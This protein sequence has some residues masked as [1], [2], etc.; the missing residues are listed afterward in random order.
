MPSIE[1]ARASASA[2]VASAPTPFSTQRG[3]RP[4]PKPSHLAT[5]KS[6]RGRSPTPSEAAASDFGAEFSSDDEDASDDDD[7]DGGATLARRSVRIDDTLRGAQVDTIQEA[8]AKGKKSAPHSSAQTTGRTP[9]KNIWATEKATYSASSS[10]PSLRPHADS[11]EEAESLSSSP[12]ASR[13]SRY[14]S[15]LS[16]LRGRPNGQQ[17]AEEAR[18]TEGLGVDVA[19]WLRGAGAERH[20][21]RP[22]SLVGTIRDQ[23]W[24]RRDVSEASAASTTPVATLKARDVTGV[25]SGDVA[26]TN[27]QV[28]EMAGISAGE[29]ALTKTDA[30][31]ATVEAVRA[32]S[33]ATGIERGARDEAQVSTSKGSEQGSAIALADEPS[34]N[35]AQPFR[36]ESIAMESDE[37][38][39][40]LPQGPR[41][42]G[43]GG[44]SQEVVESVPKLVTSLHPGTGHALSAPS[45][46]LSAP[47]AAAAVSDVEQPNIL[48]RPPPTQPKFSG[49]PAR[50]LFE[51]AGEA[52]FNELTL[53][54]GQTFEVLVPELR[55]GWSLA[56]LRD[57]ATGAE[58]R[59]LV[60]VGWYCYIQEF[61][62][63][64]HSGP[65]AA[66]GMGSPPKALALDT[67]PE[68]ISECE[69]IDEAPSSGFT[70]LPGSTLG[71]TSSLMTRSNS[72]ASTSSAS[73]RLA[74]ARA[75]AARTGSV[76]VQSPIDEDELRRPAS[77]VGVFSS[78]SLGTSPALKALEALHAANSESSASHTQIEK[79]TTTIK[80]RPQTNG[81]P[82]APVDVP[83]SDLESPPVNL[84]THDQLLSSHDDGVSTSAV[85]Q[86]DATQTSSTFTWKGPGGLLGGR[87][88][89]RFSPFVTSGVEAFLLSRKPQDVASH[90]PSSS[91]DDGA[92]DFEED[93]T[94]LEGLAPR[95]QDVQH[96]TSGAHGPVWKSRAKAFHVVVHSPEARW[97]S[98]GAAYTAYAVTSLF[99]DADAAQ[100]AQHTDAEGKSIWSPYDPALP[101]ETPLESLSVWR[102][103]SQFHWLA[104][105]ISRRAPLLAQSLPPVP[106][107]MRA[108]KSRLEAAFVEDR[109]RALGNW[110]GRLIR[111]PVARTDPGVLFF[112]GCADE[113]EWNARAPRLLREA[114]V[115]IE[116]TTSSSGP[117]AN[118]FARTT[119][120]PWGFDVGEAEEAGE[121]LQAFNAAYER[122]MG[123]ASGPFGMGIMGAFNQMRET[124]R[125]EGES[126]RHTSRAL[127]RLTTGAG[128]GPKGHAAHSESNESESAYGPAMGRLGTRGESGATNEDGAWC[129]RPDCKD[130]IAATR[131]TQSLALA[132]EDVGDLHDYHAR[133]ALLLQH[134][135]L[136][137][138]SRPAAQHAAILEVHRQTLALYR[139][140]VGDDGDEES[141]VR[142]AE[143]DAMAARCETVLNITMSEMD[144]I[145]GERVEDWIS[146]GR[147]LLDDQIALH[148][149]VLQRLQQA[150]AD[151]QNASLT[152]LQSSGPILHSSQAL[153]ELV[154]P[155]SNNGATEPLAQPTAPVLHPGV[156]ST[157]FRPV[158]LAG[159]MIGNL[160]GSSQGPTEEEMDRSTLATGGNGYAQ[161]V[162]TVRSVSN[163]AQQK[164]LG[165]GTLGSKKNTPQ[166]KGW[167]FW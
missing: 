159:E 14:A 137:A 92:F 6:R 144:R 166:S 2:L 15:A 158:T 66:Q 129:W 64:P 7:T 69:G 96:V 71:A 42:G 142:G 100:Y 126:F 29:E 49:R 133:E 86:G 122:G 106:P 3:P 80:K 114:R 13:H 21:G 91:H 78:G 155:L 140:A 164:Y 139:E 82:A 109:R 124:S 12:M 135:R 145:H 128:L 152:N 149:N 54:A 24:T 48:L 150:R 81:V 60:P 41:L 55:G 99:G 161:N 143:A 156:L 87:K 112:L 119:Y 163:A 67:I 33:L 65:A 127:L 45:A 157:T 68:P 88:F 134:E 40:L 19:S 85:E 103:F 4:P 77:G 26:G 27:S 98:R 72:N 56:L 63:S 10:A 83:G 28:G 148:E 39:V 44:Q 47:P 105:Y 138:L 5:W 93:S 20:S 8:T 62:T 30:P 43:G 79:A 25:I 113:N 50:A 130:C 53:R 23:P 154:D 167:S 95:P 90:A 11:L 110:L 73:K 151:Y 136:R 75:A 38:A 116:S 70:T 141:T 31:K 84:P 58:K 94:A 37:A 121:R 16:T 89:N 97:D 17:Q 52:T 1:A 35:E 61:A 107:K 76:R 123:E 102:R 131:S 125:R 36:P 117:T 165:E 46:S 118:F 132:L 108:G 120:D 22:P 162:G 32:T 9:L 147:N 51:F 153:A 101:P 18:E 104:L 115:S 111:H 34:P 160:F 59:G 146:V 74:N 57:P